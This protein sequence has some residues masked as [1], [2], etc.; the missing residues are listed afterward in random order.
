MTQKIADTTPFGTIIIVY[1]LLP[2][3]LVKVHL[4]MYFVYHIAAKP[5]H[6]PAVDIHHVGMCKS[7][8]SSDR[9]CQGDK[10]CCGNGCGRICIAPV[11]EGKLTSQH[12][13]D[14]HG[15]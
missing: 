5:G 10:K 2:Y 15:Q 4:G 7:E 3:I 9:D 14:A 12:V 8:C 13:S 11:Y 6:C 1:L